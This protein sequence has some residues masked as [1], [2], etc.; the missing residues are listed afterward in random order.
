MTGAGVATGVAEYSEPEYEVTD[1]FLVSLVVEGDLAVEVCF[2]ILSFAIGVAEMSE[3]SEYSDP[4]YEV[5]DTFLVSLA[6]LTC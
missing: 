5:A 2:E 3:Y 1:T 4:V 6:G